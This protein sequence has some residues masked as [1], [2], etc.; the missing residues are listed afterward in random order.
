MP[1]VAIAVISLRPHC[2]RRHAP[3][4]G[5]TLF[6][7]LHV[8]LHALCKLFLV[9]RGKVVE[10]VAAGVPRRGHRHGRDEGKVTHLRPVQQPRHRGAGH[11]ENEVH[12]HVSHWLQRLGEDAQQGAGRRFVHHETK[13]R[14]VAAR[15]YPLGGHHEDVGVVEEHPREVKGHRLGQQRRQP[16][17]GALRQRLHRSVEA[18]RRVPADNVGAEHWAVVDVHAGHMLQ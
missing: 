5:G 16:R 13:E 8:P 3:A 1:T 12:S 6:S 15:L 4:A 17:D 11:A 9:A 14:I 7:P 10:V 18:R 2:R